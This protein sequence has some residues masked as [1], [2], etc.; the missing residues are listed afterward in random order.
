M[1]RCTELYTL[2]WT[3]DQDP[4]FLHTGERV[5]AELALYSCQ[6]GR[7]EEGISELATLLRHGRFV[8]PENS[9]WAR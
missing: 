1:A 6:N 8:L 7:H 5:K 4:V 9:R 3:Y 2:W